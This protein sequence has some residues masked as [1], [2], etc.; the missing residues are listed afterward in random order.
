MN[1]KFSWQG[2]TKS[3]SAAKYGSGLLLCVS[4]LSLA[5]LTAV[6]RVEAEDVAPAPAAVA[7]TSASPA[8]QASPE[9]ENP[10]VAEPQAAPASQAES[11]AAASELPAS[12][13]LSD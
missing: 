2:L 9:V 1:N 5:A 13:V 11:A 3:A 7:E 12:Q 6:S 8:A 10:A 4:L